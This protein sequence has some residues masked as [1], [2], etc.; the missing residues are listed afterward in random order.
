MPGISLF[1]LIVLLPVAIGYHLV[2]VLR[3]LM[4][5]LHRSWQQ[6]LVAIP[7]FPHVEHGR[8]R[9]EQANWANPLLKL[10]VEMRLRIYEF[11]LLNNTA[12][13][14]PHG[15]LCHMDSAK[16]GA[17]QRVTHNSASRGM[18]D[19]KIMSTEVS[20]WNKETNLAQVCR[21]LRDE[22]LRYF[23]R[24]N[25][26]RFPMIRGTLNR[27]LPG[28]EHKPKYLPLWLQDL[29]PQ[30]LPIV[31]ILLF[32]SRSCPHREAIGIAKGYDLSQYIHMNSTYNILIDF[33]ATRKLEIIDYRAPER[34]GWRYVYLDEC[35]TCWQK[36]HDDVQ[37][38]EESETWKA[39]RDQWHDKLDGG[40][41]SW[42]DVASMIKTVRTAFQGGRLR[43][44][45]S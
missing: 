21:A 38:F 35:Q 44:P 45:G 18:D 24:H 26:F 3:R 20:K 43:L 29:P 8:K 15:Y 37:T 6:L 30:V 33:A 36:L 4:Q 7:R 11:A 22:T 12:I 28:Y 2:K 16:D 34:N 23:Y 5:R 42:K 14:P 40:K 39:A 1:W 25:M 17:H 27:G 31:R 41:I 19:A 13:S 9:R 32:E 10:P